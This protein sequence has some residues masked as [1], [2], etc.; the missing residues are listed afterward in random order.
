MNGVEGC[1][2]DPQQRALTEVH[3]R[4]AFPIGMMLVSVQLRPLSEHILIVRAPGAQDR[5]GR[6][7]NPPSLPW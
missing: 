3:L 4:P 1:L 2:V 7:F 5:H 6:R